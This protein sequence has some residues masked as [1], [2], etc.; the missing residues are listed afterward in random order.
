MKLFGQKLEFC[1]YGFLL[2]EKTEKWGWLR[3]KFLASAKEGGANQSKLLLRTISKGI[4]GVENQQ[5]SRFDLFETSVICFLDQN[6]LQN[7]S[8]GVKHLYNTVAHVAQALN[9]M[10]T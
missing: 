6:C 7:R 9:V 2:D 10:C 8:T 4:W 3:F 1:P 5:P